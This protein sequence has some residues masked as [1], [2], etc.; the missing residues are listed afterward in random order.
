MNKQTSYQKREPSSYQS[1]GPYKLKQ[2]PPLGALET[3]ILLGKILAHKLTLLYAARGMSLSS[4]LKTTIIPDLQDIRKENLDV[5]Y[6]DHWN[7]SSPL[8]TLKRKIQNTLLGRKKIAEAADLAIIKGDTLKQ[9]LER[10]SD[11]ASDPFIVIFDRFE[12]IFTHYA[13]YHPR[14][15]QPLIVQ[16]AEAMT[17]INQ[18]AHIVL[19]MQEES[20]AE[21]TIFREKVPF[22]YNNYHRLNQLHSQSM[23]RITAQ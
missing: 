8:T 20:L 3:E 22:L 12:E 4:V 11:Y 1:R 19:S 5:I 18:P 23:Q 7:V 13:V 2:P 21:L 14:G 6:Y 9:C 10:C 15:F 17:A 16:L